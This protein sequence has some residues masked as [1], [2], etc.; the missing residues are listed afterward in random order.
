MSEN[1]E[2]RL[3]NSPFQR[4]RNGSTPPIRA[5]R[6]IDVVIGVDFGT[7]YTKVAMCVGPQRYVWQDE[8]NLR[9]IPTI[10]FVARDGTVTSYPQKP[11]AG[12]EKV[13]YIKMLL[14]DPNGDVF[15]SARPRLNGRPI[16]EVVQPLVAKFLSEII[17]HV[18][19]RELRIRPELR[20][21]TI[22]WYVN[23][24]APASHCDTNM[25]VFREAAAVAV[26][27]SEKSGCPSKLDE[28]CSYYQ[29]TSNQI[30]IESSPAAIVPELTA[31]L[32][33]FVRDPNR[34]DNLYGFFDVGGGTLDGAIF[35]INR[36]GIGRPLQVH[37]A[38]VDH[39]GTMALSRA[40]LCEIYLN[41]PQYI[42]TR[43]IGKEKAPFLDLPLN[44][45][46]SF[47]NDNTARDEIQNLVGTVVQRTKRQ[48]YGQM[49]SPRT[50]ATEQ[51]TPPLR[52][53]TAGGGAESGWYKS[54]IEATFRDRSLNTLGLTGIRT[55]LV[56][57]PTSYLQADYP[58][59]VVA[60]GLADFSAAF[61][62]ARLPSEFD[63]AEPAPGRSA[64][65]FVSKDQV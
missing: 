9:L 61:T 4:P 18:K 22:N 51:D 15:K 63:N 43:L 56:P 54:A 38:R 48:L 2:D 5:S 24:G 29:S 59:F 13:E 21:R 45:P 6:P 49:F 27:W 41:L 12:S 14:A 10:V 20:D 28:L 58:R 19:N 26:A 34:A 37:A 23:V 35:R 32:H 40:L 3:K 42:E 8:T 39:C 64:P 55:E 36:S 17:R 11:Q 31:A 60:L 7:R 33:E 52:I 62:D 25:N 46:F 53:F 30:D 44:Q 57:K 1:W 16:G 47:R 65:S 50:D